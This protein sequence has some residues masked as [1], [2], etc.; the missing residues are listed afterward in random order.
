MTLF[1]FP[2]DVGGMHCFLLCLNLIPKTML[3]ASTP[4]LSAPLSNI[5]LMQ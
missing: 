5:T 2:R 1:F 3:G 4:L